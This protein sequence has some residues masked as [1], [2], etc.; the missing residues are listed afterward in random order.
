[1]TQAASVL[2]LDSGI[3]GMTVVGAI[4]AVCPDVRITYIADDAWFPYGRLPPAMLTDRI[5]AL[6]AE[7][8][9]R[10]RVDAVVV[11]CNTA[12]TVAMAVLRA[13]FP[14]PFVGV[15]PPV[16]TAAA[17]SRSRTIALL[18]TEGTARSP[19]VEGLIAAFAPD[20][21]VLRVGCPTLA[22]L[23]EDKAR[24][25]RVDMDRLRVDLAPLDAAEAAAV[26]VVVLGCTHY[27]L[28]REEL[29]ASF[30]PDVTWLDPAVPVARRLAQVLAE[31]PAVPEGEPLPVETA[32]F[33]ADR[34][35]DAA[36]R[37][38]LQAAGFAAVAAWGTAAS[39]A[40]A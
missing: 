23:A 15:V 38:F 11:A 20:C 9:R 24:G 10:V 35:P 22:A 34:P 39:A 7:A 26:D 2:V 40:T 13:G 5:R 14:L 21:R 27:P 12:T 4:R 19:Y 25:R 31:R 1:M 17:L 30:R 36:L 32:F 3:G 18:A 28:L 33:T 8:R 16:K 6:V 37:P 29:A